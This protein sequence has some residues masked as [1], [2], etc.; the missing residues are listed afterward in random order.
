M[1]LD[2]QPPSGGCELKRVEKLQRSRKASQPP[3]GGC[4]LKLIGYFSPVICSH[5]PPSGGCELKPSETKL[6]KQYEE[7]AA[8]GR[9]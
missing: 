1:I 4:E 8:F 2:N 3:S 9:L 5:Q 7:P 6:N